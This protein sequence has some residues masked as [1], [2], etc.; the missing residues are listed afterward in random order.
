MDSSEKGGSASLVVIV[1]E[2]KALPVRAIPYVTGWMIS[3]DVVASNF[4]RD[5]SKAFELLRNTS[6]YHLVSGSVIKLLPKEWDRYVA[7]LR[8][9]ESALSRQFADHDQSY[10]AWTRQSVPILPAGAFVWLDEFIA[11]FKL[12]YSPTRRIIVG[13]R[14]GDREVNLSPYLEPQ[15]LE[16]VL[17]GWLHKR[18][19]AACTYGDEVTPSNLLELPSPA[20]NTAAVTAHVTPEQ[21]RSGA[22]APPMCATLKEASDWLAVCGVIR[23]PKQ[24]IEDGA[25]GLVTIW[26]GL[27]DGTHIRSA[28]PY[29][30]PPD[31]VALFSAAGLPSPAMALAFSERPAE[32]TEMVR[33]SP[34][35]CLQFLQTNEAHV[36]GDGFADGATMPDV[37]NEFGKVLIVRH[38]DALRVQ[39]DDL[40]KYMDTQ[41]GLTPARYPKPSAE[42]KSWIWTIDA[43]EAMAKRDAADYMEV[44]QLA[45][46]W[47][48]RLVVRVRDGDI[49][50][51]CSLEKR[52]RKAEPVEDS[53]S[54]SAG[55][56]VLRTTLD[57][58]L[59]SI[60]LTPLY[61]LADDALPNREQAQQ[62][63][64]AETGGQSASSK[65]RRSD[66]MDAAI[67]AARVRA[68][69]DK[70]E[71][72]SN[73]FRVLALAA[74]KS[75][76]E[77]PFLGV[78]SN[79]GGVT[80]LIWRNG[81][82][83]EK[84]F[85]FANLSSRLSRGKLKP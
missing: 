48:N 68:Q 55:Y 65:K 25:K 54:P 79:D 84:R 37:L 69:K 19:Q 23:S 57:N 82:G 73:I 46:N 1:A 42:G 39:G 81:Q 51:Y 36:R 61:R 31:E 43:A 7:A 75:P 15:V 76:A 78:D 6:S 52:E 2:R 10:A 18:A 13:E 62:E 77:P 56:P 24:I 17:G 27:P 74:S 30:L 53:F 66:L 40:A 4:A 22:S 41:R 50:M 44:D 70:D 35:D 32:Q 26:A 11:D 63:A 38:S 21:R 71:S 16:M 28:E 83:T 45:A 59:G 80:A 29:T 72:P 49:L 67:S 3:P 12:D 20:R 33:L 60:G 8:A 64:Q 9:L 85:T 34:D 5:E 14:E 58:W 47:A